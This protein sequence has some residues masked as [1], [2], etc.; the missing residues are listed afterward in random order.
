MDAIVPAAGCGTCALLAAQVGVLTEQVEQLRRQ[1]ADLQARLDQNSS[2][3]HKPPSSDPPWIKPSP[4]KPTGRRPGGQRGHRGHHRQRL[5]AERVDRYV[6]HHPAQCRHCHAALA[7]AA[8]PDDPP[9]AWHQVAEL[10][11]TAAIVT[12]HQAHART[13][14]RCGRLTRA[15]IPRPTCAPT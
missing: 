8:S 10:P 9:P 13:C 3:S 15:V 7:Q 12:E 4:K 5:P 11:P 1:V 6:H 14:P 2:N